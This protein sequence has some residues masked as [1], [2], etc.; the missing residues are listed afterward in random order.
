MP[1]MRGEQNSREHRSADTAT[2]NSM[3]AKHIVVVDDDPA[4]REMLVEYLQG[5]RF[6]VTAVADGQ[7]MARVLEERPA[8]LIILDI[9]LPPSIPTFRDFA[10]MRFRSRWVAFMDEIIAARRRRHSRGD[11][12]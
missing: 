2:G 7:A 12:R 11:A 3:T 9:M 8:D 4:M 10:R 6:M 5:H 1:K